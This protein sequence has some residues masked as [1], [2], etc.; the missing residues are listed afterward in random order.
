M[1]QTARNAGWNGDLKTFLA[2]RHITLLYVANASRLLG[3]M[4][5]RR[6]RQMRTQFIPCGILSLAD[7]HFVGLVALEMLLDQMIYL[8][9]NSRT[10]A[11]RGPEFTGHCCTCHVRYPGFPCCHLLRDRYR[12]HRRQIGARRFN[13]DDVLREE[14]T[15]TPLPGKSHQ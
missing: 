15:G 3:D 13:L 6:S 5:F 8:Q 7:Q 11:V 12:Q 2:H 10:V 4:A 9:A 1:D 14:F